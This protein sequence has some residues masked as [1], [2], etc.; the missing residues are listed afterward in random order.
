[1]MMVMVMSESSDDAVV[2]FKKIME[3]GVTLD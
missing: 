2:V 3:I 1:M